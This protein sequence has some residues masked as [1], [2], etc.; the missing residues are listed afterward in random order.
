MGNV[1][2]IIALVSAEMPRF[3][4]A[5]ESISFLQKPEDTFVS[6]ARGCSPAENRN[7][8]IKKALKE[9]ATHILFVDDD[10]TF[11]PDALLRLLKHDL[12][13]VSGYYLQRGVPFRPL[14]MDKFQEDM[15]ARWFFPKD[16]DKGLIDVVATG[17]G[18]LLINTRIFKGMKAP[19]FTLGQIDKEGWSDDIHFFYKLHQMNVAVYVDLD[20]P[21]GHMALAN[22]WPDK[23]D[24]KW[25][26]TL[27]CNGRIPIEYVGNRA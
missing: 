3:A 25:I 27:D 11:Q 21:I 13:V 19:Y 7:N 26:T 22:I 14:L 20:L 10:M 16:T 4:C 6:Y 5:Y 24:G 8:V 23:K 1:K 18:F 9:N 12:P 15:Q 2:V 17:A